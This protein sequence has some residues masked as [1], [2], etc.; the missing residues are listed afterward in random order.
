[1]TFI[2]DEFDL[3]NIL[4]NDFLFPAW[5]ITDK[6]PIFFSKTIANTEREGVQKDPSK[7]S[8]YTMKFKEMVL[9][10]ATNPNYFTS[11]A[12]NFNPKNES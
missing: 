10:S 6:N 8:I 1:M 5:D 11:A 12:I 3:N 4:V 7:T 2:P 9:A